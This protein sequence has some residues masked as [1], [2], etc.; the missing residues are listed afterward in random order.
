MRTPASMCGKATYC[1]IFGDMLAGSHKKQTVNLRKYLANQCPGQK[2]GRGGGREGARAPV[3]PEQV[4][5]Y[6]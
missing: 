6:I 2:K 3:S 1:Q 5:V 4:C